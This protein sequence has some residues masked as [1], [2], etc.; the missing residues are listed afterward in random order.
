MRYLIL[1]L[2]PT[3]ALAQGLA[4]GHSVRGSVTVAGTVDVGNRVDASISTAPGTAVGVYGL[5]GT[6]VRVELNATSLAAIT[7]A[8]AKGNCTYT[9]SATNLAV[10]ATAGAVPASPMSGRTAVTLTNWSSGKT[11]NCA[12]GGTPTAALGK[13]ISASGGWWKWEGAGSGWVLSCICVAANG[14]ATTG[15]TVQVEEEKCYQ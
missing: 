2:L 7:T 11:V 10:G 13:V 5:D 4:P 9:E 6:D 15:C 14:S 8:T 3:A 1:F 12:P